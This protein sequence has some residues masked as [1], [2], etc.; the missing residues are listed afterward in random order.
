MA[1]R[2][3]GLDI[4]D[5]RIGVAASDAL[6][7]TAQPV[8]VVARVSV[9]RDIE[10]V[11]S[12]LAPY[13]IERFVAGLPLQMDGSEGQQSARSRAFADALGAALG[14]EV[15]YQD[16]RMTSLQSE[17]MLIESGM[18]RDKRRTVI[19]KLAATLILQ[20]YMDRVRPR[21]EQ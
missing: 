21:E 1:K 2:T 11:R 18:R 19:D 17:R 4:G 10:A 3:I 12:L 6:G 13:E 15:V 5:K 20:S 9:K 16:E 14:V 8:G 7:I